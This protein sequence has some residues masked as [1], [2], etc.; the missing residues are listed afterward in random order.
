MHI[1]IDESGVFALPSTSTASVS[2]I[3][4][5]IVPDISLTV[6]QNE[7][8]ELAVTW[9]FNTSE[10]K[11]RN[12]NETQFQT[13]H[14][15]LAKHDTIV[16]FTGIDLG[17][18]T[19]EGIT[20]HRLTQAARLT[21][22]FTPEHH[23]NLLKETKELAKK[24]E[25]LSNQLYIQMVLLHMT[26]EYVLQL[27][28]IHY[29]LTNPSEL[30]RFAW[31]LDAKGE[32][33]TEYEEIWKTLVAPFTESKSMRQPMI[34]LEGADYS[35]F[36]KFENPDLSTPPEHLRQH[37]PNPNGVFST[38]NI[39]KIMLEDLVFADSKKEKGLQFADVLANCFRRACHNRLQTIGWLGLTKLLMK[40]PIYMQA[41][42]FCQLS[43]S[44][45]T[46]RIKDLPYGHVIIALEEGARA[47][48][49]K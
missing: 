12:L 10:V 36:H 43:T 5:L 20:R 49:P 48:L 24:M 2:V 17:M 38:F 29:P 40:H 44:P 6:L 21:K 28:V 25:N 8:G 3:A 46:R 42:Q 11:G 34:F 41:I 39:G 27:A 22:Y 14:E 45:T 30:E 18:H 32:T 35:A 33:E 23:P 1:F 26:I 37:I 16:V 31:R 19:E 9:G 15:L 13:I 4:A 7:I 47:C